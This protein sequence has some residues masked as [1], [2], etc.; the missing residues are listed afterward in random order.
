MNKTTSLVAL[1]ALLSCNQ[2]FAETET[3]VN[4]TEHL[5]TITNVRCWYR[6]DYSRDSAAT[7]Y[8]WARIHDGRYFTIEGYWWGNMF[9][10]DTTQQE[11]RDQCSTTLGIANSNA[12]VTYFAAS[13]PWSLNNTIWSNDS[14]VESDKIN[15]I[16]SFGDSLSDT[17]NVFGASQF[18]FPDRSSWFL[19]HFSNGFVWT[20]YLA[21]AKNLPVYNW[22]VGGSGG[23]SQFFLLSGINDQIKSY[24]QY[25]DETKNY[26]PSN[27]LFTLEFGL[28]DFMQFGRSATDVKDDFAEA[29]VRLINSGAKNFLLIT[30]PDVT[31][32]PK[33]QYSSHAEV[34]YIRSKIL[35]MNT[36]I[37]EQVNYYTGLGYNMTLFDTYELFERVISNPTPYGFDNATESCLSLSSFSLSEYFYWHSLREECV[38]IGSDKFLFWDSLHPT[39][40]V[41]QYVAEE[42]LASGELE[43]N[44]SF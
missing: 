15:K 42:I 29:L 5:Q 6:T 32:A 40:A 31:N 7:D 26:N 38:R 1:S 3:I 27:T 33:F 8:E 41:H 17:G 23:Q 30:L 21:K 44:H 10:T 19:G 22:A 9:Y 12:D 13:F 35:D 2:V 25:M 16:V 43:S 28:N 39:T 18:R 4:E 37:Q 20:E 14:A 11:I 24:L 34:E 36:F